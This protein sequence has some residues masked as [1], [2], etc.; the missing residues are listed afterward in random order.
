M[1]RKAEKLKQAAMSCRGAIKGVAKYRERV[2]LPA[3]RNL[4]S[5]L[6]IQWRSVNCSK[7]ASLGVSIASFACLFLAPPVGVGLGIGAAAAG[8]TVNLADWIS[9]Q[10]LAEEF[11]EMMKKDA[12][13]H[14]NMV[15]A[16]RVF[17]KL[18]EELQKLQKPEN[19][20][21]PDD[22]KALAL[23]FGVVCDATTVAFHIQKLKKLGELAAAIGKDANRVIVLAK[24][25]A[26][27]STAAA[28]GVKCVT[29][30]GTKVFS[31]VGL[32][33]SLHDTYSSWRN[34][35]D[36]HKEIKK[37]IERLEENVLNLRTQLAAIT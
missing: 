7:T 34:S 16:C 9:E 37:T 23:A 11:S 17:S 24:D 6:N 10:I 14:A 12:A 13:R 8:V 22:T 3:L 32:A 31:G 27:L 1:R 36:V 4:H 20:P 25:G 15:T 21:E 33:F 30:V 29:D 5:N 18:S 35:K 28:V 2:L 26:Y 19:R